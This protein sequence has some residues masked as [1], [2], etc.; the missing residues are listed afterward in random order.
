[1]DVTRQV[2]RDQGVYPVLGE[3][4]KP[5]PVMGAGFTWSPKQRSGRGKWLRRTDFRST[6]MGTAQRGEYRR[7]VVR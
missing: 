4:V 5:A 3:S 1:M 6:N 2:Y 7:R